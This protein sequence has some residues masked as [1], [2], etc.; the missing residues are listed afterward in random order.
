[1]FSQKSKKTGVLILNTGSP[2]APTPSAVRRYLAQFLSD[3]RVIE[4]PRWLWLPVLHGVILNVRPRRSARLYR[5]VWTAAGSPLLLA[6][7]N[8]A[9]Q[10]QQRL[11][12]AGLPAPVLAGMRYGRP[13]IAAALGQLLD[14]GVERLV[15]LPLFPQYSA[16]T[17]AAMLDGVYAALAGLRRQ[18]QLI[19]IADY[20]AHP[21]YLEALAEGIRRAWSAQGQAEMMLFSFH[22]IPAAYAAH[23]D[24]YPQHCQATAARLADLLGLEQRQWML[25]YQS[26]FG[27]QQWLQPYTDQALQALGRRGCASLQVSCPGFAVDCLETLDEIAHEGRQIYEQAGGKGFAYLPALNDTP[28]HAGALAQV[29][30]DAAKY[31]ASG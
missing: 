28:T 9:Q 6:T 14:Q 15:A 8:L 10:L 1:M 18:P 4:L 27:P 5:R 13:S 3:R 11:A 21:A 25:S 7:Q 17:S 19:T 22:G 16:T 30:L 31:L 2:D 26:R 24:P 29:A 12:Q 20:H 23:G